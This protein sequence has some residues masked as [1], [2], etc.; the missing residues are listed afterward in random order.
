MTSRTCPDPL[1]VR[2]THH[3]HLLKPLFTPP[4]R[5]L[6]KRLCAASL[7]TVDVVRVGP[8]SLETEASG[9][10]LLGHYHSDIY[11]DSHLNRQSN[12]PRKHRNL[13]RDAHRRPSAARPLSRAAKS[14]GS[15]ITSTRSHNDLVPSDPPVPAELLMMRRTP[16]Q[17]PATLR[18]PSGSSTR[19]SRQKLPLASYHRLCVRTRPAASE[20]DRS[21]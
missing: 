21:K 13:F 20:L 17:L 5:R 16:R 8:R 10:N 1:V 12:D 18:Q 11:R 19:L 9:H 15:Q 14:C 4:M 2:A 7:A 3:S 6:L